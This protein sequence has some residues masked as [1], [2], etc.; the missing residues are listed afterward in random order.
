MNTLHYLWISIE[1]PFEGLG[2]FIVG[3]LL[4]GGP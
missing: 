3:V 4:F 2:M 1:H